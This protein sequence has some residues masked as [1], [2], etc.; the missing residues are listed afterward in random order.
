MKLLEA[1]KVKIGESEY[2]VKMSI[3]AMIDYENLTG[4]SVTKVDTIEDITKLFYCTIKAGGSALSYDQFLDLIDDNPGS[5]TEFSNA[6]GEPVEK[7]VT[8]Q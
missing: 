5:I 1:K 3:R 7:K 4:H 6:M 2:P 8:D